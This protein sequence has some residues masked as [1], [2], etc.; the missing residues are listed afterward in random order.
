[1][2]RTVVAVAVGCPGVRVAVG[3][4]VLVG[5]AVVVGVALVLVDVA[6]A[7]TLVAVVAAVAVP[8]G[9]VAVAV[10]VALVAVAVGATL[11]GVAV[12]GVRTTSVVRRSGVGVG[13]EVWAGTRRAP[14]A[15]PAAISTLAWSCPGESAEAFARGPVAMAVRAQQEQTSIVLKSA[16]ATATIEPWWLGPARQEAWNRRHE[17]PRML[18]L[19]ASTP[20]TTTMT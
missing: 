13:V 2:G 1:V 14:C 19:P 10:A 5:V 17:I 18:H 6:V 11:V 4:A 7:V 8:A 3:V 16:S 9:L 12:V 20:A 15:R